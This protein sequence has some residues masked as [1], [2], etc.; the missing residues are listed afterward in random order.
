MDVKTNPY[1][2]GIHVNSDSYPLPALQAL[3]FH[4]ASTGDPVS[5]QPINVIYRDKSEFF[6]STC[7]S[8]ID[9]AIEQGF[10]VT[11][12]EFDPFGDDG[13]GVENIKN[14]PYMESLT[15]VLCPAN[16][17]EGMLQPA[18]FACVN[19][20]TDVI[21]AR[22]RHNGCRPSVTWFTSSTWGW[23]TDNLDTVPYFQGGGQ[24][25]K[26]FK[27]SDDFFETG[28]DILDFGLEEYGYTG[29]YDHVVSYAIP[30]LIANKVQ[31][32]F[33]IDDVPDV[34]STFINRYED[35]R[36]SFL[37]INADTIFG[38]VSFNEFQRNNGRGGAGTQW[39]PANYGTAD[40]NL[41]EE[42]IMGCVS[43]LDQ[44]DSAILV[45]SPSGT[46]CT[47]GMHVDQ[48]LIEAEPSLLQSK[49]SACPVDTYMPE[50]NVELECFA[51]PVD[52]TTKGETG[53]TFCLTDEPNLIPTGLK[54]LGY[55]FVV[56]S[57]SL[58][59]GFIVWMFIHRED[60]VIKIGQPEFL[61][62]L[63]IG[64][65]LSSSSIIPLTLAEA[66][67]DEETDYASRCCQALP[68]LYSIGW[69]L[70]YSSLTAKSYRL[71]MVAKAASRMNRLK[72][73]AAQMYKIVIFFLTL[74]IIVLIAWQFTDP[75]VYERTQLA[76]VVDDETGVVTIESVGQCSSESLWKF[77][78]PI[79]GIQVT[80][81]VITNV[82]LWKVRNMSDRY[83]EQK[84]VALASLY[85]CELLLLGVPILIAVQ[86]SAAARYMVIAGVIF[87]TD[88][89]VLS[90]V[91]APKI[92]FQKDGLPTGVSVAQSLSVARQSNVDPLTKYGLS[93]KAES[94]SVR[95]SS[96]RDASGR[97]G[98][99]TE[100]NN[101]DGSGR[102]G[103]PELSEAEDE[104][105]VKPR[106]SHSIPDG[107]SDE[108]N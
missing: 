88:T 96:Y 68:F 69:V 85:T 12:I 102:D 35:L 40:Q 95:D 74:D 14:V 2:F 63:C 11:E 87:L 64:A 61:L 81:M 33:R 108:E 98:S 93:S 43:P 72:I 97:F 60:S 52:S 86:D 48:L 26:N 90:L 76:K 24:W 54:S 37:Y 62:M 36:K 45:P 77:I 30:T 50:S 84:F 51:C 104:E 100:I 89:G 103:I 31:S 5:K 16:A 20:E 44:A 99:S 56:T 79:I 73:T 10:A 13:S 27:Y 32:F 22:M 6:Y 42:F 7:R 47:P 106:P 8:V 83:Q 91:F 65:M 101:R 66:D 78:G 53:A 94:I 15:D 3:R 70:M 75:L 71:T 1:V 67:V 105:K 25:H 4:L 39:I 9:E 57:W 23:A 29:S 55:I 92:K 80:L 107:E 58:A 46:M 59:I 38:P 19:G 18:I 41:S 17:T 34:G 28:Q 82:L 21:L 49:C